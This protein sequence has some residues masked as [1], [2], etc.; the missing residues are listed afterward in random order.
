MLTVQEVAALLS[1][2]PQCVK[3]WNRHGVIRG[4]A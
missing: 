4:H 2:T 1:V 3:I